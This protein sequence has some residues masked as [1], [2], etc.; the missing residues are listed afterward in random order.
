MRTYDI[1]NAGPHNRFT[2]NGRVVSN[3]GR[4]IQLQNLVRNEISTLNEARKLVK[5]GCFDALDSIYESTPDIL[6]QLLRTMLIPKDGCEFIVC[7]FSAI[8]ARVLAWLAGEDWV[9]DAFRNNEDLY[10]A[11][12]SRMFGVPV[13]KHG[14]NGELRQYGKIATLACGY[15]GSV[16]ALEA[17]GARQMGIK[18]EVMTYVEMF[19]E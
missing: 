12:A 4:H 8:E 7:D 3:S 13:V 19:Y 11:T 5:L 16:G 17:F 10:C 15:G 14:I 9:L 6:S 18:D 2:A 1:L